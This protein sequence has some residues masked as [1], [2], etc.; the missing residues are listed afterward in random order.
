MYGKHYRTAHIDAR[1]N[2]VMYGDGPSGQEGAKIDLTRAAHIECL[3]VLFND[4]KRTLQLAKH[5][6]E[7]NGRTRYPALVFMVSWFGDENHPV[8]PPD[9]PSTDEMGEAIRMLRRDL[10]LESHPGIGVFHDDTTSPHGHLIMSSVNPNTM[11]VWN[12][13]GRHY[14][15][16]MLSSLRRIA[17]RFGWRNE[18]PENIEDFNK[19]MYDSES[20][21]DRKDIREIRGRRPSTRL[22]AQRILYDHLEKATGWKDLE[23]RL[24]QCSRSVH[25]EPR[26]KNGMVVYIDDRCVKLSR[27][28]PS[29]SRPKLKKRFGQTWEDYAREKA[30]SHTTPQSKRL[31]TDDISQADALNRHSPERQAPSQ[32]PKVPSSEGHIDEDHI[33]R[34]RIDRGRLDQSRVSEDP[35]GED[36]V[37]NRSAT[38]SAED[39]RRDYSPT[40]GSA[41]RE[42]SNGSPGSAKHR[43]EH[44]KDGSDNRLPASAGL[45]SKLSGSANQG[46]TEMRGGA[47]EVNGAPEVNGVSD[48]D[49]ASNVEGE[50]NQHGASE[51]DGASESGGAADSAARGNVEHGHPSADRTSHLPVEQVQEKRDRSTNPS[52]EE[53]IEDSSL[54]SGAKAHKEPSH[55]ESNPSAQASTQGSVSRDSD[56]ENASSDPGRADTGRAD[57]TSGPVPASTPSGNEAT[58]GRA[59]R[60]NASA[61]SDDAHSRSSEESGS[62]SPGLH[63]A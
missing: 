32:P 51:L 2:Y 17:L 29:F 12:C 13:N 41:T 19:R 60:T 59:A 21:A 7:R 8:H 6:A 58:S 44:S 16:V 37:D 56:S 46:S 43:G 26:R 47:S 18:I 36:P 25:L 1:Y 27:I 31:V 10:H 45:E 22:E 34:G 11:K 38:S 23:D 48:V 20:L 52:G 62:T 53:S 63:T 24:S 3:G 50:S 61:S 54:N 39:R 40:R 28:H 33:N 57:T 35:V 9:N 42:S 4:P 14:F 15:P 55:A 5:Y 30:R 49:G